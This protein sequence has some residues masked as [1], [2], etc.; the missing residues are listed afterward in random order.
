MNS[1]EVR[2]LALIVLSIWALFLGS[3]NTTLE[4]LTGSIGE[5]D[6]TKAYRFRSI[7]KAMSDREILFFA[8]IYSAGEAVEDSYPSDLELR[9]HVSWIGVR[10]ER[11]E[12]ERFGLAGDL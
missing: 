11:N 10:D 5:Y 6:S 8:Q 3:C 1:S 9:V 2:C 12:K 7:E 4:N